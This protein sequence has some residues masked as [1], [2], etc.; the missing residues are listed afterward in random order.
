MSCS[1][2]YILV[3][4]SKWRTLAN[5]KDPDEMRIIQHFIRVYTICKDK[6]VLHRNTIVLEIIAC[7][8]S[9][10]TIDLSHF[11]A[12]NQKGESISAYR[13]WL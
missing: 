6:N 2:A 4:A 1:R 3:V 5:I 10:Y 8:P 12:S 11:I 9:I 13:V 7:D